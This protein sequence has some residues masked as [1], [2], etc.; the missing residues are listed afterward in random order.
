MTKT[1]GK[2]PVQLAREAKGLTRYALA[3][4]LGITPSHLAN[5]ENGAQP[6]VGLALQICA[7][8]GKKCEELFSDRVAA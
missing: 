6:R 4:A 7:Q 3:K 8:L 5:I 1:T 2:T